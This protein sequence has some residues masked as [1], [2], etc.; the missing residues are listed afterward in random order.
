MG[1]VSTFSE[2]EAPSLW[3]QEGVIGMKMLTVSQIR[4]INLSPNWPKD[5]ESIH[6]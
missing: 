1:K 3:K 2:L 4:R 6:L 5:E